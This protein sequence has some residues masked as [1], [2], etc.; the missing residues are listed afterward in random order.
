MD[1]SKKVLSDTI[2]SMD[3]QSM[4][5]TIKE[6]IYPKQEDDSS[7]YQAWYGSYKYPPI[8]L[9]RVLSALNKD[10][11]LKYNPFSEEIYIDNWETWFLFIPRKL[12]T[13]SWSDAFLD[14]QSDDTIRAILTLISE[15]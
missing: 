1:N 8:S 3:R 9:A 7:D 12:L 2:Q 4:L 6:I 13:D 15:K 10:F 5:N 14:D 11:R